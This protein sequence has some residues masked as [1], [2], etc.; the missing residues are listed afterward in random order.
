MSTTISIGDA[1]GSLLRAGMPVRFTAYDGSSAGPP[2][3]DIHVH[4][5][6]ER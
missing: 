6:N 4:L 2:D 5:K 1:I 3:S